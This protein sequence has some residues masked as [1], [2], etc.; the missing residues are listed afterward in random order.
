VKLIAWEKSFPSEPEVEPGLSGPV[1][2]KVQ[3][4]Q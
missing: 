4:A 2:P 3:L 1:T